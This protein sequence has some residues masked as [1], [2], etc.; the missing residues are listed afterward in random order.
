MIDL[1]LHNRRVDSVFQLLGKYEN[2]ISFS[3]GWAFAK[4][5]TFLNTFLRAMTRQKVRMQDVLVRLQH[6]ES[7]GGFTDIEIE[8]PSQVAPIFSTTYNERLPALTLDCPA[9]SA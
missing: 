5:P 2:D 8:S 9:S 4:C 7:E 1:Y 3:I 6:H